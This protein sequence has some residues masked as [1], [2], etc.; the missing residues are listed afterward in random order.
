M[1]ISELMTE[2]TNFADI[3]HQPAAVYVYWG[4][5][6]FRG[7]IRK[8]SSKNLTV[9]FNRFGTER[10]VYTRSTG[11]ERGTGGAYGSHI[12]RADIVDRMHN[13]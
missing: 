4:N 9:E 8:V 7:L 12:K 5:R 10:K 1:N 3:E 11:C 2:A 6:R 13:A